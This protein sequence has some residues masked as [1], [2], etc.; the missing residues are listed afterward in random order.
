MIR[1]NLADAKN[2]SNLVGAG[3]GLGAG[4]GQIEVDVGGGSRRDG[5]VR[6]FIIFLSPIA[7]YFYESQNLPTIQSQLQGRTALL[8]ELQTF[9]SKM[10]S[11]VAEIKKFKEDEA[12]IQ[13]RIAILDKLSKDRQKEI[14]LLDLFQQ[15]I[16]EKVWFTKV[17]MAG[18]KVTITGVAMSDFD[19]SSFMEAL[20]R[21][22]FLTDVN[23]VSSAEQVIEGLSTKKFEITCLTE[24]SQ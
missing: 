20:S 19:I 13:A 22:I 11:S 2:S 24:K 14:R 17:D 3:T 9:N 12:K 10:T 15:A 16:P 4:F 5:L 6:L 18:P 7:L 8:T 23:L 21:S 1:I